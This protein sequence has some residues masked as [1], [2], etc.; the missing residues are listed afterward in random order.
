[1]TEHLSRRFVPRLLAIGGL[2][3]SCIAVVACGGPSGN[4][5]P[6]DRRLH[7]LAA[8]PIFAELPPGA[9]RS[10]WQENPAKYRRSAFEG[11]GWDGPS[12][13]LTFTSSQPAPGVYGF[14]ADRARETG[15]TPVQGKKL[16]NGLTWAWSKSIDGKQSFVNLLSNPDTPSADA[17]G[18]GTPGSYRLSGST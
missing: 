11:S 3:A 5:D 1:M 2:V 18:S 17:T 9:A 13:L 4:P 6:G 12:V 15:W 16:S 7:A 10:S 8:D 14:Y